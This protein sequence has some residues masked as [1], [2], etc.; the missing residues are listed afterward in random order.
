MSVHTGMRTGGLVGRVVSG[1]MATIALGALGAA[2]A[3]DGPGTTLE[4]G[5][6]SYAANCA[7]CHGVDLAGTERGPSLLLEVYGPDELADADIAS[8]IRN[9]VDQRLFEF[10]PMAGNGGL[11]DEQIDAIVTFVR[12][13]QSGA[14]APAD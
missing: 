2:C 10:G 12:E 7:Q 3:A 6:R 13:E 5:Q 9:G 8:A 11:S 4:R 14:A 1:A